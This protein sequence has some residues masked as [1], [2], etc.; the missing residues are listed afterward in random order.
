MLASLNNTMKRLLASLLWTVPAFAVGTCNV[1][2]PP[3]AVITVSCTADAS[4]G[5]YPAT[6]IT[7]LLY[8][9]ASVEIVP[10]G[11]APTAGFS[12]T[13]TDFNGADQLTGQAINLGASGAQAFSVS[14]SKAQ[15]NTLT[16]NITGNAVNSATVTV[17]L[18][19]AA[20]AF[21][22]RHIA[23][24]GT[25]WTGISQPAVS[26]QAT[27]SRAAAAG[28]RHVADCVSFS[29]GATTAVAAVAEITVNL[30]DGATG[31]GTVIWTQTIFIAAAAAQLVP[32]F[33][34]CGLA[35]LGSPNTAMT[36]E[37]SA[38]V[39]NLFESVSV[40]GYDVE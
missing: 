34:V 24:K 26:T 30:R 7:G 32:T 36:L 33:S 31:A 13:I 16:L 22:G 5:S 20:G 15:A 21:P 25:R 11:T 2:N 29:G 4:T 19:L 38:L 18:Y 3:T 14:A 39:T 12:V 23:E 10:G 37:F 40:S 1:S 17:W 28:V 9:L 35:L 27:F 8:P 6:S